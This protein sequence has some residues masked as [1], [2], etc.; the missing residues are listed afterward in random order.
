[1]KVED[2][3][4]D[5]FAA[6]INRKSYDTKVVSPPSEPTFKVATN[7]TSSENIQKKEV[8]TAKDPEVK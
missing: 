2:K 8:V 3:I 6:L 5:E 1:M 7:Y 4:D